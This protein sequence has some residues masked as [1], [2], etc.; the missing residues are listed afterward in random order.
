MHRTRIVGLV[1]LGLLAA[2]ACGGDVVGP[3]AEEVP[4]LTE[5]GVMLQEV[6]GGASCYHGN[7]GSE[8]VELAP[9]QGV[10]T[11]CVTHS[12]AVHTSYGENGQSEPNNLHSATWAGNNCTGYDPS[13]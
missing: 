10:H 2:V 11:G 9:A 6:G 7:G 1:A 3:S 13:A 12:S 5:V 4:T 8:C